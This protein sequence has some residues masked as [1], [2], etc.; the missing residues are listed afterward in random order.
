MR[1]TTIDYKAIC[2]IFNKSPE[3]KTAW[4]IE[5][6]DENII[7][8]IFKRFGKNVHTFEYIVKITSEAVSIN[9]INL[10]ETTNSYHKDGAY[11]FF[12]WLDNVLC[13]QNA[14]KRE[15]IN[16]NSDRLEQLLIKLDKIF[17]RGNNCYKRDS[18]APELTSAAIERITRNSSEALH[19]RTGRWE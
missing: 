14:G 11:S 4:T 9:S 10:Y 3:H 16:F 1:N 8:V 17:S 6:I 18:F 19:S 13:L 5:Y 15:L 2:Q 7:K 12:C